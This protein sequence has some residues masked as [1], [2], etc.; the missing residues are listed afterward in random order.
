MKVCDRV[1]KEVIWEGLVKTTATYHNDF[2]VSEISE[3][4]MNLSQGIERT[5]CE[6]MG[7]RCVVTTSSLRITN[8]ED[9]NGTAAKPEDI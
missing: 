2:P 4:Y 3:E 8:K 1:L 5:L 9:E 6:S 7:L